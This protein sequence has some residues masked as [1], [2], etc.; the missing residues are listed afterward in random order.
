MS[1]YAYAV[2]GIWTLSFF[3]LAGLSTFPPLNVDI[4]VII[5]QNLL[6]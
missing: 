3:E 5:G 6:A 2:Y 1:E 4:D